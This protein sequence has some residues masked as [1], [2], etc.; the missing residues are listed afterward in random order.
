MRVVFTRI[1]FSLCVYIDAVCDTETVKSIDLLSFACVYIELVLLVKS[2]HRDLA[3]VALLQGYGDSVSVYVMYILVCVNWLNAVYWSSPSCLCGS[4]S[5]G[6]CHSMA[7][8]LSAAGPHPPAKDCT[9]ANSLLC[10]PRV[11]AP[12][13]SSDQGSLC[14]HPALCSTMALVMSLRDTYSWL[15][16]SAAAM[17]TIA[18]CAIYGNL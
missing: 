17:R 7:I 8:S 3:D 14:P 5:A 12:L 11:R 1:C 4:V 13:W 15:L 6:L 2:E 10:M 16:V 18:H 9:G